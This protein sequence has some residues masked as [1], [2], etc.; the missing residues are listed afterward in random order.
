MLILLI[1]LA[2][3]TAAYFVCEEQLS[4]SASLIGFLLV[5][6]GYGALVIAA[7]SPANFL[8][9]LSSR[10]T[11]RLATLSYAIY[12]S[13][14]AIVHLTQ[15]LLSPWIDKS[16]SIMFLICIISS[17]SGGLFLHYTIEKPFM[18]LRTRIL[19]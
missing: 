13:H 5:S 8:Y 18:Q 4:F 9:R 16:G 17:L 15:E 3:L 12:L 19:R 7:V 10:I 11:T 6:L 2:L 1:G 14:K